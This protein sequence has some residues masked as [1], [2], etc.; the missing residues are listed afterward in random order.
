MDL[1]VDAY[2]PDSYIRNEMQ[3]LDV[4]KRIA[5]I[6]NQDEYEDMLEELLDRFGE[7]PKPVQNLLTVARL[8][9]EA[10]RLYITELNQKGNE[11]WFVMYEKAQINTQ[12]MDGLLKKYK[13]ELKFVMDTPPYFLYKE[14]RKK[15]NDTVDILALVG[16][17]LEDFHV[18]ESS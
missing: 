4:Y 1:D 17:L 18:L 12:A 16:E 6:R 2:I 9:A 13:G 11:L 15:K 14:L 3:K 10:H 5:G 7:P 8:K